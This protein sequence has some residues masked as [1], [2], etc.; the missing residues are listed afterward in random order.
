MKS[1]WNQF[2]TL[3]LHDGI[4]VRNLTLIESTNG[5]IVQTVIPMA[6]RRKVLEYAHDIRSAGHLGMKKTLAKR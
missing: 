4:L 2:E 1:M 3:D 5:N 6:Y